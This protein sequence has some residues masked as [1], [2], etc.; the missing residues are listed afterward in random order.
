MPPTSTK[1]LENKDDNPLLASIPFASSCIA[2]EVKNYFLDAISHGYLEQIRTK[3][4]TDNT[5]E[6]LARGELCMNRGGK[7]N[8]L[9]QD[10]KM[11]NALPTRSP[12]RSI[13]EIL[14][15]DILSFE[16]SGLK[17]RAKR[18]CPAKEEFRSV[19]DASRL[20]GC[21]YLYSASYRGSPRTQI[22]SCALCRA[23]EGYYV[24]WA[25]TQLR[26]RVY[27]QLMTTSLSENASRDDGRLS[28]PPPLLPLLLSQIRS[29]GTTWS[30]TGV[31]KSLC[32]GSISNRIKTSKTSHTHDLEVLPSPM[33][34][35]TVLTLHSMH[36]VREDA[37]HARRCG[38]FA[39]QSVLHP[40]YP[41]VL[42]CYPK[43]MIHFGFIC[44]ALWNASN[45]CFTGG[46]QV[47]GRFPEAAS[48]TSSLITG[49]VKRT[50]SILFTG[51]VEDEDLLPVRDSD[52]VL[53][54]GLGGNVLGRCLDG[55]LPA[56]VGLHVVEVEPAVLE[57]CVAY[58][59][60]P[61]LQAAPPLAG[62]CGEESK[63]PTQSSPSPAITP[64]AQPP[65][66]FFAAGTHPRGSRYRIYLEDT[67]HFLEPGK[68]L[69]GDASAGD[70]N[71][72]FLD[73]YDPC[74]ERM[75]HSR[76]L[77]ERCHKRLRPCGALVINA[78][79]LP[80]RE[81][82]EQQFLG[83]G[84]AS[85]QVLRVA[86]LDQ[87][88]ILCLRFPKLMQTRGKV[89]PSSQHVALLRQRGHRFTLRN[90]RAVAEYINQRR[91]LCRGQGHHCDEASSTQFT[92]DHA[93]FKSCRLLPRSRSKQRALDTTKDS[94]PKN[95]SSNDA[96][97][98]LRRVCI[99][100]E[101]CRIWEH[102]T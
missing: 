23:L 96:L 66:E 27:R 64:P 102:F 52:A 99:E 93:W 56:T 35:H 79:V 77:L 25:E 55:L 73:C 10:S 31:R 60:L 34:S 38:A 86:G 68:P 9:P 19:T 3:G 83:Y 46:A 69:G 37:L 7:C 78:H 13:V 62:W 53:V 24:I 81:V 8:T 57:A 58:Q 2:M 20:G 30:S 50:H 72:I 94:L 28:T 42:E 71:M 92:L 36:F 89:L 97:A 76:E 87:S 84:F 51:G 26:I 98:E 45:A 75:M 1:T 5:S 95:S 91:M 43:H 22:L 49:V 70:Y 100:T 74:D 47:G 15:R 90:A 12:R 101:S 21:G 67:F 4:S 14:Q 16:N 17:P 61:P 44:Y 65:R 80:K 29:E 82:L 54:L 32:M 40:H 88:I 63:A 11:A 48:S 85:V 41:T 39:L 6:V 59:Q 33:T 18:A